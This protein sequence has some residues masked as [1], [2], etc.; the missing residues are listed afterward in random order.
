MNASRF[1]T[2]GARLGGAASR[3][4]LLKGAVPVV[5]AAAGFTALGR[6]ALANNHNDDNHNNN[7]NNSLNECLDRCGDHSQAGGC[8]RRCRDKDR[9]DS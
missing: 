2:L 7:H 4:A 5:A 8:A 6:A 1:E 9:Q 3:R